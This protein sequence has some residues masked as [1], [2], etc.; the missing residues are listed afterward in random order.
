MLPDGTELFSGAGSVN[1]LQSVTVTQCV[2]QE[3]ELTLGSVCAGML[4]ATVLAPGGGVSL[5][6]GDEVTLCKVDSGGARTVLGRFLLEKPT[7]SSANVLKLT[8]YD[9]VSLLDRD[10]SGWLAGLDGW[11]YALYDFAGLVC[12]ACGLTLA[13]EALPNGE[14]RIPAFSAGGITGRQLMRWIGEAAGRFCRATAGGE[15]EFAWYTPSGVSIGPS[16]ERYFYRGGLSYE[17]Y[18]VAPIEKVQIRASEEDVGVIWPNVAEAVNTY[19]VTGN[20]LLTA[21][22]TGDLLPIAQS[23]Y[24]TLRN[25]TYTPCKVSVPACLDI[26]PGHTVEITDANGRAF[27]AYVM[28]KTQSGQKDTLEATGSA[29]RD[30][31]AAVN[32]VSYKALS[33]KVLNLT[34]AVE[35]LKVSNEEVGGKA[36]A[37]ELNVDGIIAKVAQQSQDISGLQEQMTAV[38]HNAQ[39][40]S[41]QI[42]QILD[43]GVDKVTTE[44]G[45]TFNSDGLRISKSGEE[46][47]NKLDNTGMYV[48]R[49]GEPVLQANNAG[50]I[51]ADVTVNNY[52]TIGHARFEAYGTDRTACFYV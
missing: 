5:A 41:V 21:S 11:P 17:D 30:S 4:E 31:A 3:T 47:D 38:E 39:G 32:S 19:R 26:C 25:V 10:L 14:Y 44:T 42:R 33:G 36:A 13:N 50:V 46:M 18:Q 40:V 45:Y 49:S 29:R 34:T 52:L 27:T 51:A 37:L 9:R 8:G 35:G 23:L 12:Q 1:A 43:N 16:G 20:Y 2:N 28:T 6:A 7:R 48:T 24:E 22:A 15:I